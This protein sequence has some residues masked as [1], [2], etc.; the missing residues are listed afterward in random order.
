MKKDALP[1]IYSHTGLRGI[2]AMSVVLSHLTTMA[3]TYVFCFQ[4]LNWADYAVDLF[5]ILSGFILNY[6][7][8]SRPESLNWTEYFKARAARIL[9]LYYL[10]LL[11]ALPIDCYSLIKHGTQFVGPN[12]VSVV[13][14]DFFLAG[15]VISACSSNPPAWSISSEVFC[16]IFIFPPL[17]KLT[18]FLE[19]LR[20]RWFFALI[21]IVLMSQ[22]MIFLNSKTHPF[23][24]HWDCSSVGKGVSGFIAGY[25]CCLVYRTYQEPWI[26]DR[27]VS[28][29]LFLS[30][31]LF[32]LAQLNI[33]YL[34]V[35][36]VLPLI[37]Y[38]SAFDRGIIARIL[39]WDFFQWL[40]ERSYSIYLWHYLVITYFLG[41]F[42]SHSR[43][44]SYVQCT[45]AVALVGIV[46]ELSY[47]YFEVPCRR[48]IRNLGLKHGRIGISATPVRSS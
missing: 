5:F 12:F 40:G 45:M 10:T 21:I 16:Y 19:R 20:F 27:L 4:I 13:V 44:E 34:H 1:P 39:K 25:L 7:Y 31:T 38:F 11:L 8:L 32:V 29:G 22:V 24:W 9:P 47:R 6:V 35:L 2:A 23:G 37:V 42:K 17:A 33:L 46:A 41:V 14:Q 18:G 43:M 26:S 3:R 36:Y 28:L 48:R 15:G 30:V